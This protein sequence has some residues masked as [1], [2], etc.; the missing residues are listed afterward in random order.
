MACRY[1]SYA[2]WVLFALV[3]LLMLSRL[4]EGDAG[5]RDRRVAS[6]SAV[7][8]GWTHYLAIPV[9]LIL[10][11]V[12]QLAGWVR[13]AV[14]L[15]VPAA[16]TLAP[17]GIIVFGVTE[18]RV[19][20]PGSLWDSLGPIVSGGFPAMWGSREQVKAVFDW[21]PAGSAWIEH[22]GAL[23]AS[24]SL[25]AA[26]VAWRRLSV[27]ARIC[28]VALVALLVAILAMSMVQFVRS[29][30]GYMWWCF[31]LPLLASLVALP[32]TEVVRMLLA[33]TLV[34][35][36]SGGLP[37]ELRRRFDEAP[38]HTLKS[39]STRWRDFDTWRDGGDIWVHP[40]SSYSGLHIYLTGKHV[41]K[42]NRPGPPC[43][44]GGCFLFDDV[45]FRTL[46]GRQAGQAGV[47]V[48]VEDPPDDEKVADCELM[49]EEK[50]LWVYACGAGS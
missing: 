32:R 33:S 45:A 26:L 22:P 44:D 15:W 13:G 48:A 41:R 40:G 23:V 14:A 46:G 17:M 50:D 27:T 28:A 24:V 19:A 7:L 30:V 31:S 29:P 16:L 34:G 43:D 2:L 36:L 39:I 11:P 35:L 12:A 49:T 38:E 3:H 20:T 37:S 18:T 1:R 21:M 10:A 6:V 5:A 4:A 42:A 25:L 9:S 47:I 8:L